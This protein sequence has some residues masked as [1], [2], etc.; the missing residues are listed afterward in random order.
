V[1]YAGAANRTGNAPRF[2]WSA[3]LAG[4]AGLAGLVQQAGQ[5]RAA[6]ATLEP[7]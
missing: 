6:S 7:W 5:V 3:G 4:R 2:R 1:E